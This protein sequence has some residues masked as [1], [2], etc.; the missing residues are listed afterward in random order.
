[1][2]LP[3]EE[4][5]L[6][7]L[8]RSGSAAETAAVVLDALADITDPDERA[9]AAGLLRKLEG[10]NGTDFDALAEFESGVPA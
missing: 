3:S 10:M 7:H 5:R 9:A 2:M 8:Y 4:K 6:L 1:M